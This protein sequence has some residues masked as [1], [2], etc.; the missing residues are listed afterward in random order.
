[1]S[2]GEKMKKVNISNNLIKKVSNFLQKDGI[3]FFREMKERYNDYSP[4]F[5]CGKFPYSV[6]LHEGMQVRNFLRKQK[7]CENWS[8]HD[9]DNNWILVIEKVMEKK[10]KN[11]LVVTDYQVDFV[12]GKLPVPKADTIADNIQKE[13]DNYEKY[14]HIIYLFDTHKEEEYKDSEEAKQFELHCEYGT[15]GWGLFKIKPR[16]K[17][18][19]ENN[20]SVNNMEHYFFKNKFNIWEG[21]DF[22]EEFV[23]QNFNKDDKFNFVGVSENV[24]VALG[25]IGF[26]ERGYS[27]NIIKK[28]TATIPSKELDKNIDRMCSLGN[29]KYV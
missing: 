13:I 17:V 12:T 27:V 28:C 7:E 2:W 4:V 10:M 5:D 19:K 6:H 16:F 18:E 1:M 22:F 14:D 24:C 25:A 20:K 3:N 9:F 29:I 26:L 21:N 11:I 23:K 15:P 8:D